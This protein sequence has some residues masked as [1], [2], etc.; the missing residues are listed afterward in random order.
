MSSMESRLKSKKKKPQS[1]AGAT[2][3]GGRW[4]QRGR[5]PQGI[6]T[7]WKIKQTTSS[8]A[9]HLLQDV[10]R[11]KQHKAQDCKAV[12]ATCRGC[13]KKGHYEK[14]CLQGKCSAH[15]L[16][17]PQTTSAGAGASEPLYFND[18]G[19][20]VYTYM[21]SVPHANK[22]LIRFPVT[23]E[24]M[25]LRRKGTNA[26]SSLSTP[27]VLLKADTGGRHQPNEQE[28]PSISS[29]TAKCWSLH[30]SGWRIMEIQQ[31]KC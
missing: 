16:E 14:V 12:D 19:Q 28:G 31:W 18:E 26:D 24:P 21:V 27:S 7:Q 3:Q 22:H 10:G 29:L 5:W 6:Q 30:P 11:E 1:S 15:S 25:A 4:P 17:T 13:G 2:S 9:W 23:I 8:T 20:P